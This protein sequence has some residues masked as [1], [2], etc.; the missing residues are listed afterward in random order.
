M[1]TKNKA[2]AELA[3]KR[4]AKIPKDERAQHMPKGGR[5]RRYPKCPRYGSHR[6]NPEGKCPCGYKRKAAK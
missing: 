3:R 5:T 2:A 6:F 4:W 1:P